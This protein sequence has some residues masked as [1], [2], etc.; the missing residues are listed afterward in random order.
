M[1][2]YPLELERFLSPRLWGG[3]RLVSYLGIAEPA[4]EEPLGESWQVYAGCRILNGPLQG[5]TLAEVSRE[6]GAALLGTA[7]VARYGHTFPLL[8][9][10]IDAGDKLSI[11]VH[12]DD[13]YAREHEA[14]TGFL[15]KSEAWYIL[16]AAPGAGVIWG[17]KDALTPEAVRRAVEEERLEEHLNIVPVHPGEVI[18]NPAGTVHAIGAGVFLFEIQQSSDLTYRLYDYGRRGADGQPRALHLERALEVADLTPVAGERA[19]V[20]PRA[21]GAGRT[22][23]L[24]VEHFV[25]ERWD[26]SGAQEESTSETS[27]ELLTTISGNLDLFAGATHVRLPQGRSVV[28]PA[29]LGVY[30]LRGEGALLRAFVPPH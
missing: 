8:A 9:K 14:D 27:V 11:Q 30:A 15:G 22:E 6:Y 21:L 4:E 25:L 2:L 17:F 23:L 1:T 28:L 19:K 3:D 29:S 10:F 18:Y 16:E 13:A 26:V 24:R 12:P 5:R 7:P 20:P